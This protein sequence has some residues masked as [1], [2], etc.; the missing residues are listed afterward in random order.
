[1]EAH[2][3]VKL[4]IPPEVAPLLEER[5]ILIEDIQKVIFEAEAQGDKLCH[6]ESGHFLA[7]YQPYKAVFW[8]EYTPEGEG[9]RVHNA[10]AH[11]MQVKGRARP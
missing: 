8:V 9:Y 2:R 4:I 7:S 6:P 3:Q 11:R 10:Y 1:M 5:R